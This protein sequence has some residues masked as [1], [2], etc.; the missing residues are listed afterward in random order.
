MTTERNVTYISPATEVFVK[1]VQEACSILAGQGESSFADP[2]VV[3]GFGE[4]LGYIAEL[5]AK[6]LNKGHYEL[7]D[8]PDA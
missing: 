6:Y 8:K 5:T 1:L 3:Q 4:Y 2:E 7:L